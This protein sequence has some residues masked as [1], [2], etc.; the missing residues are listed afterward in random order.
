M[1]STVTTVTALT[2]TS[3]IGGANAMMG[4][5][6]GLILIV[7]LVIR[8][9]SRTTENH[10]S[11]TLCR[12]ITVGTVPLLIIFVLIIAMKIVQLLAL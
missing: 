7:L 2:T 4:I 6:G 5:I 1:I 10:F 12:L 8:E 9:M 3:V 11:K